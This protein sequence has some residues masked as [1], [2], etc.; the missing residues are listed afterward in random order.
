MSKQTPE[1][2]YQFWRALGLLLGS[3]VPLLDSLEIAADCADDTLASIV[4][5]IRDD[6]IKGM[7]LARA[8][9]AQ[10]L[11][12][13]ALEIAVVRSG[14]SSGQLDIV[15]EKLANSIAQ[16][17]FPLLE[18]A[19]PIAPQTATEGEESVT[20]LVI[21]ILRDAYH[22]GASDIHIEFFEDSARVRY[23]ING[24]LVERESLPLE[25][26]EAII[27]RIKIMAALDISEKR[28]PQDGRIKVG[29]GPDEVID[30]RV[31]TLPV[32]FGEKICLRILDKSTLLDLDGLGL[33]KIAFDK[34]LSAIDKPSGLIFVT[35]PTG[36]GKTVSLYAALQHLNRP[37]VCICSA[38][39]PVE[40]NFEGINQV[41]IRPEIGRTFPNV[42]KSFLRQDPDVILVGEIRDYETLSISCKAA[43]TGRLV[44]STLHTKNAVSAIER[45]R[46][47]DIDPF[48]ITESVTLIV[49]Q[50]LIKVI[51]PHCKGEAKIEADS[52]RGLGLEPGAMAD[53]TF[54]EGSGCS[55]CNQTGYYGRMGLFE[56]LSL[57][58]AIRKLILDD[59]TIGE[60]KNQAVSE[61]LVPFSQGLINR[62]MEGVTDLKQVVHESI[63]SLE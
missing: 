18:P 19:E 14:E 43:L 7:S 54:Y 21:G 50:R 34:L 25:I 28:R 2:R 47:I 45:L 27:S 15:T 22:A 12:F 56:V 55:K 4:S 51:C 48:I 10:R 11:A 3:G 31:A 30:L 5:A 39:D 42:L 1:K 6:I 58:P 53:K 49:A 41:H 61:G 20:E 32:Q 46:N 57:S 13:S 40:Y 63:M 17:S 52:F 37:D 60:I 33:E 8:M 59:A 16:S 9:E 24:R 26:R 29:V 44:L 38:E 23:R 36:S 35:G 62:W